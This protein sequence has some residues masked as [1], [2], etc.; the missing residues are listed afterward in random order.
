[1]DA[2]LLRTAF[3]KLGIDLH[4]LP[5]SHCEWGGVWCYSDRCTVKGLNLGGRN[6]TG[7]LPPEI[8]DLAELRDLWLYNNRNLRGELST[9]AKLVHLEALVLRSTQIRG[10]LSFVSRMEKM[11]ILNLGETQVAGNL[12][13]LA[14]LTEMTGLGLRNTRVGGDLL[15][16]A[17]MHKMRYLYLGGTQIQGQLQPLA[18]LTEM[19]ELGLG[20]T[21]VGGEL[22]SLQAGGPLEFLTEFPKLEEANLASTA[23]TGRGEP[24]LT[25]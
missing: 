25:A 14:N 23:V 8:G 12:Q 7:E 3:Q 15:P 4:G 19:I 18:N 16:L 9:L 21:W 17:E 10:D 1:P 13:P 24:R 11:R 5:G 6:L 20:N 2:A 22:R